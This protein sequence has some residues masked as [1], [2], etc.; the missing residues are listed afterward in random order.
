[1]RRATIDISQEKLFVTD[2][3]RY[4]HRVHYRRAHRKA[5]AAERCSDYPM[6]WSIPSHP[7][8]ADISDFFN[9]GFDEASW[10]AYA[11]KQKK[12]REIASNAKRA[13]C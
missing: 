3:R 4:N 2:E 11:D 10:N 8:G 13:V 1:M 5:L 6:K 12:M 9:Y 7:S